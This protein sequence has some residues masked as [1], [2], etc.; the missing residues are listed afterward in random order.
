MM[1]SVCAYLLL[2]LPTRGYSSESKTSLPLLP[3]VQKKFP[4]LGSMPANGSNARAALTEAA[5]KA[6]NRREQ[7]SKE[8]GFSLFGEGEL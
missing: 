4:V 5:G 8:G 3:F 6:S 1:T 7:I 2:G